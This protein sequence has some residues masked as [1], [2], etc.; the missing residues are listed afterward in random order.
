MTTPRIPRRALAAGA[1]GLAALGG[2]GA[3]TVLNLA[4]GGSSLPVL[5]IA[6]TAAGDTTTTVKPEA[7]AA[8][9]ADKP[10]C[11][12]VDRAPLDDATAAKVK[13]AALAAVPNATVDK[14]GHDRRDAGYMALLTKADGTTRVLVHEDADFKVTRVDDPAPARPGKRDRVPLDDATAAKVKGA[15]LAAVPNATVDKVGHD[16]SG[17]GYVALLTKS[18]GTTRVLVHEDVNFKVTDVR[19]P[20]PTRP[21]GGRGRPG[22]PGHRGFGD[23]DDDG[24]APGA[25]TPTTAAAS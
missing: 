21:D 1:L 25:T 2:A 23:G 4:S 24:T 17:D 15:A 14:V 16:R 9:Q 22:G 12:R 18:D 11:D 3:A 20:A 13:A 19:D 7:G 6:N 10:N 5:N 8:A